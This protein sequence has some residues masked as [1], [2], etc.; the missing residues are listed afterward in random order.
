MERYPENTNITLEDFINSGWF[1][2]LGETQREDYS[3]MWQALSTAARQASEE[4]RLT[5]GKV[6]WLL[7]DACSMM[8]KPSSLN[9]PFTPF[10]VM[11][12]KRSAL[13]ED[14]QLN[15]ITFFS[16]IVPKINNPK[17]CSR[18]SD[19][20]WLL[21]QP[22]DP[23]FALIAIDNY[24]QIPITTESW[25]RDARE[26]WDRA[27]Q[28][29]L[30]LK[31]G[32][33]ER[34][35]KIESAIVDSLNAS[36]SEDGY[37]AL[38]LSD[39][40]SKHK[41]GNKDQAVISQILEELAIKFED[42]G[43][44]HRSR[45][46]FSAASDWYKKIGSIEKSTEMIIRNAEGWVKEAIARQASDTPSHMVAASFYENAIQKYRTISKTLRKKFDVDNRI[47]ELRNELNKAGEQ[48]LSEMSAV[49]S[50]PINITELIEKSVKMVR[51]KTVSDALLAFAN[52]YRGAQVEKIRKFSEE[53]LK[54][55]P[56]Q[57]FFT[58]TH[59]SLDGRVIA[60]RPGIDFNGEDIEATLM[61]EMVKH[62]VMELSL[63]V[64]GDI[65]PALEVI[66]QEHRLKEADF[67]A[68]VK[69]S[70]I[71]PPDRIRLISKAIYLGYDNDFI[72]AL[73]LLVPQIE[74]LVRYH[75]KQ[76]G[77]KTTNLDMNGIENENGLSTLMDNVE[78]N[79]IFG[80]D[81]T[82]EIKSLFCNPF[83]PNLRNELAHGLIGYEESQSIYSIYAW[84]L[85]FRIMYNTFWNNKKH[86]INRSDDTEEDK[87][88]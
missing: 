4:E 71:I 54:K 40:L 20:V 38:W 67:Y 74:N 55:H 34:L 22:R 42:C 58:A 80:N 12:G 62:Y 23:K 18:I 31:S 21:V 70:P 5:D 43:E 72:S 2:V 76:N 53:M 56:M 45:D 83:G 3:S 65:W 6:L 16:E 51:G 15:D 24:L 11:D 1:E 7:A 17:L 39:L 86:N 87:N 52:V 60:K 81:L 57:S 44:L 50:K 78:V 30:M 9:E 73:H 25:I 13:P 75:L 85:T 48:S 68:I 46:Y 69:Q 41:L 79:E 47:A 61:P 27:I 77:V 28:L 63:V 84:W 88:A 37:L 82:F 8:L 14:F 29:C 33:G 26:C 10:M 32:A 19:L 64:Q 36:S 66:R 59:M 49:S 35:K